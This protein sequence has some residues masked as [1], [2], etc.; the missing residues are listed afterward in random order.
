MGRPSHDSSSDEWPKLITQ[1]E[2]DVMR[3]DEL[4]E[5]IRETIDQLNKLGDRL[6]AYAKIH[7]S[8][9]DL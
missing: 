2:L 7:P 8:V 6:E 9:E 1:D 3:E 5:F 4:L